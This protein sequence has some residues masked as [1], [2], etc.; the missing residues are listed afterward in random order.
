MTDNSSKSPAPLAFCRIR[1]A[2]YRPS[3]D[4]ERAVVVPQSKPFRSGKMLNANG[5][6]RDFLPETSSSR[7]GDASGNVSG[8]IAGNLDESTAVSSLK[9]LIAA[10]DHRLDPMLATITDAARQLT[11]ASGAALAMWKDGAMICRARSGD[12]A[13][14]LG[15]R[16]SAETGISGECLRT[17]KIQYC[18][19]TENDPLVDVEV[20]RSLGLRSIA[21]LPIQGWRGVN[22][23]LEVFS[24]KPA[25]FPEQS[26][27]FLQQL[28]ALAERARASQPHDASSAA[29]KPPSAM[30]RPQPSGLFPAS[31]RVGDLALAFLGD[32]SR[33]LVLGAIGLVAISLLALVIWVGRR[34]PDEADGKT[35]AMMPSVGGAT[36]TV[37]ATVNAATPYFPH[38][39]PPDNDPVWKVNPGGETLFPFSGK[40]SAGTPVKFAAKMD[41]VSGKKT[42]AD[43]SL[44]LGDVAANV[45]VPHGVPNSQAGSQMESQAISHDDSR[46]EPRSDETASTEPPSISAGSTNQSALNNDE[47]LSAKDSSPGLSAPASQEVTGGQLLHRVAPVYPAEARLLRLEGTVILAAVVTEDGTV[48]DVNVV[49]GAAVLAQSAV[50]AVKHWRYQPYELDGKPLK[51]ETRITIDFKFPS[52][53]GSH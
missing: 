36:T 6:A 14:A 13:P 30:E 23:V 19:D 7:L 29:R 33:P 51:K 41:V 18:T 20:C 16:L 5:I 49:E 26:I 50:D 34:G 28:A 11:G 44:L 24:T 9:E 40:T 32:R 17:G 22:G 21:V 10:G 48:G 15:A 8:N 25:A 46:S 47:V 12:T 27:T 45:A 31:D 37:N 43:R 53:A 38:R 3:T 4:K 2:T 1:P 35:H 42:H 39:H 52:E